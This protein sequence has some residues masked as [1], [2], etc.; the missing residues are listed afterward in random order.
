MEITKYVYEDLTGFGFN[1]HPVTDDGE[2]LVY[3]C[4]DFKGVKEFVGK[5]TLEDFII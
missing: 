5:K 2:I 3:P 1:W 4:G